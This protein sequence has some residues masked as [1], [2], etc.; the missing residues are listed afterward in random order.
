MTIEACSDT[1]STTCAHLRLLRDQFHQT[2]DLV[3]A[4]EEERAAILEQKKFWQQ[5][6]IASFEANYLERVEAASSGVYFLLDENKTPLKVIKP[7]DE[8]IA[9][10][11]NPFDHFFPQRPPL[12]GRDFPFYHEVEREAACFEID[13]LLQFGL[14]PKIDLAIVRSAQFYD[15]SEATYESHGITVE[16]GDRDKL[17]SVRDYVPHAAMICDLPEETA[18]DPHDVENLALLCWITGN[19]D[20]HGGNILAYP[21][22]VLENG[23]VL[24]GLKLIDQ[25]LSFPRSNRDHF[26]FIDFIDLSQKLSKQAQYLISHLPVVAIGKILHAYGLHESIGAWHERVRILQN[27]ATL[28]LSLEEIEQALNTPQTYPSPWI[29]A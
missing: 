12:F 24:H 2:P 3:K 6:N 5:K 10:L 13:Q 27:L 11:N 14:T 19:H 4:V 22:A 26:F 1:D 9:C 29:R 16:V 18:F 25:G 17:C 7:A 21:K 15:I 28:N 23:S 20:C 8:S